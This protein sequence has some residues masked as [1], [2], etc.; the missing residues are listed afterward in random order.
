M[1]LGT[2]IPKVLTDRL[3]MLE[4]AGLGNRTV[5]DEMPL[6]VE[7][8][9]TERGNDLRPVIDALATWGSGLDAAPSA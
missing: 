8:S 1:G 4:A 2:V 5:H 7:D 6:R 9:L 3:R